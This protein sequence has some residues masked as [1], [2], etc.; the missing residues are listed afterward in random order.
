MFTGLNSAKTAAVSD[1]CDMFGVTVRRLPQHFMMGQ[2]IIVVVYYMYIEQPTFDDVTEQRPDNLP[3]A[4]LAASS[5]VNLEFLVPRL[6]IALSVTY[7]VWRQ[8]RPCSAGFAASS[9]TLHVSP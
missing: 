2:C 8:K 1:A 5:N 7:D 9:F 6:T 4:R 3:A